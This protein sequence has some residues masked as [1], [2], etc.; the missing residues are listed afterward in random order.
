MPRFAAF[1]LS[2]GK[3]LS[4]FPSS[5]RRCFVSST[6]RLDIS[7]R[8]S[9]SVWSPCADEGCCAHACQADKAKAAE[10]V[11]A[12]ITRHAV[13][14][15]NIMALR[16]SAAVRKSFETLSFLQQSYWTAIIRPSKPAANYLPTPHNYKH[17]RVTDETCICGSAAKLIASLAGLCYK[18]DEL[19]Q[20][21]CHVKASYLPSQFDVAAR[22]RCSGVGTT[23]GTH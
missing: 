23:V 6:A 17:H 10:R 9:M 1:A 15:V 2:D 20:F 3:L 13:V 11:Q 8:C 21:P 5:K 4:D 22:A 19:S 18:A 12:P 7:C 14:L 16:D